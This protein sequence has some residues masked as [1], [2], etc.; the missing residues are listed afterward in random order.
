VADDVLSNKA[1]GDLTG[2]YHYSYRSFGQD[3]F[4]TLMAAM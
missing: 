1:G 4:P 2:N 3:Y